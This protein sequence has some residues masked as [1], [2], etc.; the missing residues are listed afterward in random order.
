MRT[1]MTH[2][3]TPFA[4]AAFDLHNS[5]RPA[6]SMA[7][8]PMHKAARMLALAAT[9]CI[10]FTST[11]CETSHTESDTPRLLGGETHEETTTT[12]NPVTGTNDTTHTETV[13]P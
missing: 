4:T 3:D 8:A 5:A 10:A 11:A 2:S 1:F 7:I 9:V 6:Q 12:H 13:T